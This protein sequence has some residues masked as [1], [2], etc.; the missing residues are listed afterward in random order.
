LATHVDADPP[1]EVTVRLHAE[2]LQVTRLTRETGEVRVSVRTVEQPHI[3]EADL[4]DWAAQVERV[5]VGRF[6]EEMPQPRQEGDVFV[7]PV[8]EEVLVRRLRLVEEVRITRTSIVR[9]HQETVVL[10]REEAVV[11]RSGPEPEETPEPEDAST[12]RKPNFQP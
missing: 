7:M 12:D 11:S 8:V 6:V 5:P 4:Q 2:D 1:D 9:R 10:R 3:V